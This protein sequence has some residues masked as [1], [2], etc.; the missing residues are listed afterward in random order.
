MKYTVELSAKQKGV[1]DSLFEIIRRHIGFN[2]KLEPMRDVMTV[3]EKLLHDNYM[4]GQA[5]GYSRGYQEGLLA[6]KDPNFVPLQK[7][8]VN[9]K[10]CKAYRLGFDEGILEGEKQAWELAQKI[11]ADEKHNGFSFS[12]LREIF[13]IDSATKIMGVYSYDEARKK[14]EDSLI[15]DE[16]KV[17]DIVEWLDGEKDFPFII[18]RIQYDKF[19]A[20]NKEGGYTLFNK[21][22]RL[23]KIENVA[24]KLQALFES[25]G[26]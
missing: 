26:E 18:T 9:L 16:I 1:V 13:D 5:E 7:C 3:D 20:M 8:P 25:E 24:D 11:C 23:K 19:T 10:D 14:F 12:E 21:N 17:G 22:A 15:K 6:Q 2:P 4:R